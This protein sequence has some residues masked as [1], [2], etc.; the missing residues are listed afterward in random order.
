VIELSKFKPKGDLEELRKRLE[1]QN[2]DTVQIE[3]EPLS[4]LGRGVSQHG[5][6]SQTVGQMKDKK[7]LIG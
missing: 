3:L 4:H 7:P 1:A 2:E 6:Y 5:L